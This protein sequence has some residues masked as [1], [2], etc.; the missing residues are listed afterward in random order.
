MLKQFLGCL[1][2]FEAN[3]HFKM[4]QLKKKICKSSMQLKLIVSELVLGLDLVVR[5]GGVIFFFKHLLGLCM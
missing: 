2:F 3:T 1:G 5:V 4:M